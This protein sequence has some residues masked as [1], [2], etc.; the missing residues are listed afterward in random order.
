MALVSA[1]NYFN[2]VLNG[3]GRMMPEFWRTSNHHIGRNERHSG[4]GFLM[5]S[6]AVVNRRS[7]LRAIPREWHGMQAPSRGPACPNISM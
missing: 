2:S 6:G 1:P 5:E 3:I 4:M 7:R